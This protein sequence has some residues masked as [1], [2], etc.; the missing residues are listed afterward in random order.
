MDEAASAMSKAVEILRESKS[1]L[2]LELACTLGEW[3][4]ASKNFEKVVEIMDEC[5]Q[6][7]LVD[8]NQVGAANDL[9][10]LGCAYREL[11]KFDLA[12]KTFKEARLIFKTEKEV[13][14]VAR[15]D[16]K[17]ASCYVEVGAGEKALEAA[18][19]AID[20]FET[21]HDH[22]RETF[23]L[24]EYG[25]A[26]ILIGKLEDGLS[27]LDGVLQIISED[28]PKDFELIVDIETRMSS[29]LRSLGRMD[30][31]KEI[32]RRLIAVR[33][34]MEDVPAPTDLGD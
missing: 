22:R 18:R 16:Q 20:V 9:H 29:V 13:I 19:K 5:A 2:S 1:P 15:C 21:G 23:A 14:Q 17:I 8:G 31:A 33:E 26:E 3:W 24:L 28:E 30:E 10:L 11:K 6:E 25:K 27:T 4:Y 32:D 12:I 7:H 34:A